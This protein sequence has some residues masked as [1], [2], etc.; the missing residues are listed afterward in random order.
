VWP[1]SNAKV[2]LHF[3]GVCHVHFEIFASTSNITTILG[4]FASCV[5]DD[6]V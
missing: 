3:E 1:L 6:N 5:I 4:E 2:L